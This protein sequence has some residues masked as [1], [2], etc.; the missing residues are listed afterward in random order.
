MSADKSFFGHPRGL[1][2]LFFTEIWERFSFYGM[3]A[4][5]FLFIIQEV[6]EGPQ[7]GLGIDEETGGAIAG[8]YNSGVYLFALPGGWLADRLIGQRKAVLWGGIIIAL[9]HFSMVATEANI[10]FF[11][12]GLMLIM[13]GT[14][15]LK[16]NISTMVGDLYEGDT[17]A[18]R[19]AGFS[20][21]YMAINVGAFAAPLVCGA[22][23]QSF[24]WHWAFGL[25]GIGMTIGVI[26]YLADQSALGATGIAPKSTV[27]EQRDAKKLVTISSLM[28]VAII[29]A[30][31][32]VHVSGM[33][34]L[35]W[36]GVADFTGYFILAIVAA[37][38]SYVAFFTGLGPVARK[39][40]GVIGILFVV[41]ALFWSAFEQSSTSI[42]VFVRD[43]TDRVIFGLQIPTEALQAVNPLFI[44]ALSPVFG[45]L[46]IRLAAKNMTPSIPLKFA[47]GMLQ[48][49]AGFFVLMFAAGLAGGAATN[50]GFSGEQG[51]VL[52]T[53]LCLTYLLF[54]TGELCLS[55]VGLSTITKLSPEKYA[56]QMMG[57]WFIAAA[58]G[59]LIAG[60]IGGAIASYSHRSIFLVV[61][62]VVGSAGLVLL[63]FVPFIQKRMMGDVK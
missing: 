25:A 62:L 45:A 15:L 26:W 21:F 23:R 57:I 10:G 63:V 40:I 28:T 22:V 17:G 37:F 16:P 53:W 7:G 47:L 61:A 14:G 18:R 36:T 58:L 60:R 49:S 46:W 33:M 52:P 4:M 56:S 50:P 38:L 31:Y 44:I 30:I 19:D 34:S 55:P 51:Q 29:G 1:S 12:A 35:T 11:Y 3:K 6:S 41:T 32:G 27:K 24:G 2:T 9:G 54:T 8:L 59:N 48:L 5:L 20:I 13:I 42:N 43:F 39:K